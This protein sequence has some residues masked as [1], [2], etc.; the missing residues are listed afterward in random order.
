MAIRKI[1]KNMKIPIAIF[2]AAFIITILASLL[3]GIKDF[4]KNKTYALKINK[5]KIDALKIE[6]TFSQGIENYSQNPQL[7]FDEKDIKVLLLDSMIKDTLLAQAAK[8]MKVKVSGSEISEKYNQIKSQF[9]DKKTFLRALQFQGYSNASFKDEIK[10]SLIVNKVRQKIMDDTTVSEEELK[11]YYE[12]NKYEFYIGKSFEEAKDDIEKNL[13]EMK[14]MQNY[15]SFVEKLY[16]DANIEWVDDINFEIYKESA[17]KVV[18]SKD[19]YDFTNLDF[20]NRKQMLLRINMMYGIQNA[21][22]SDDDVKAMLDKEI[23]LAVYAEKAGIKADENLVLEDRIK[24]LI[25]KLRYQLIE[26]ADIND[27]KLKAYFA[28]NSELYDTVE[29]ADIKLIELKAETLEEEI[30]PAEQKALEILEKAKK[31]EDFAKLAKTYSEGPTGPKGGDLGW[32]KKGQMIPDFE[33]AAFSGEIGIYPEL[34]KTKFGYHII[35]VV[36]KKDDSVKASHILIK[37][38][39]GPNTKKAA[40]AKAK[41]LATKINS[42]EITF[43]QVSEENSIL[44]QKEIKNILNNGTVPYVGQMKTLSRDIFAAENDIATTV[45]DNNRVFIFERTSYTPFKKAEFESQKERVTYDMAKQ[46]A[47]IKLGELSSPEEKTE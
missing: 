33:N 19:G 9:G 29:S 44:K 5:E 31:G 45:F 27:A 26:K 38:T 34:V 1:R 7:N 20:A 42:K 25:Q 36:D 22:V 14:K 18:Y 17:R 37:E 10:K 39:M 43:D 23:Q 3:V 21:T 13:L 6:R 28:E 35:N 12:K 30:N 4:G 46:L 8:D 32:F 47:T 40:M 16:N 15:N 11:N 2:V 41:E 24:D